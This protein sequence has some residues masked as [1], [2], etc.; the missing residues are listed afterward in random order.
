MSTAPVLE[1]STEIE[2]AD[3]FLVDGEEYQL[4]G[5]KHLTPEDEAQVM[6]NLARFDNIS[7]KLATTGDD[8][9]AQRLAGQLRDRRI[10]II[11]LLTTLPEDKIRK[12]PLPGQ[13][14]L[15]KTIQ[16]MAG[17]G[18]EDDS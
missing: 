18:G 14:R 2:P 11:G 1:L 7:V 17:L 5:F 10:T 16:Q 8:R 12:L 15:M 3:V 6:A 9:E 4:L 13:V